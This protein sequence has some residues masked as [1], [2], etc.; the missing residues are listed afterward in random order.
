MLIFGSKQG[1]VA[2]LLLQ[3]GWILSLRS[4]N[5]LSISK[6]DYDLVIIGAGASGLFA[7]G[8]A[9]S[10]GLKTLLLDKA[11]GYVGGDC[12]NS[13]CVPSKAVR[14]VARL[15]HTSRTVSAT[16]R[17]KPDD[18]DG[19]EWVTLAR[20]HATDTVM[21]LRKREDASEIADRDPNL[22]LGFVENCKFLNK[23]ELEIHEWNETSP[24]RIKSKSFLLATG[25]SP[26]VPNHL[27][28][29]A[30]A[31]DVP[32]YTY[33]S[34]LQP[35]GDPR[36]WE[37]LNQTRSTKPNIVLVGGGA[38]ACELGQSL[39][40]LGGKEWNVTIVAPKIM[41]S[42]DV[43]L[44]NAALQILTNDG[45]NVLLG[46]KV[47]NITKSS[48]QTTVLLSD[49]SE[50]PVDA[51]VMCAGRSAGSNLKDLN[52]EAA[53]VSWSSD[54]G[55]LVSESTLQS[56]TEPNIYACGDCASAVTGDNRRAAHGAWTGFHA[57]RN[58]AVP[59][60]L[61]VGSKSTH[62]FVPRVTFT[63]PE[64]A[65]VGLS[66]S[67]CIKKYGKD[68]F[69]NVFVPEEGM[70]RADMER[71][72]RPALGFVELRATKIGGVI[73][74]MTACGP[75]AAELSNEVVVALQNKLSVLD[76]ARS[77]HSYPSHGYLL[78]RIALSMALGSIYGA[79]DILGPL[80]QLMASTGRMMS[81]S[82]RFLTLL[83]PFRRKRLRMRREWEYEGT[84]AG[85]LTKDGAIISFLQMHSNSSKVSQSPPVS[86][87]DESEAASYR[88]WLDRE[89]PR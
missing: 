27:I 80:A 44:Q 24:R 5:G 77:I 18:K 78:H 82:T 87:L 20:K 73:L 54:D 71:L 79:L 40:R 52:L 35:G 33:R 63:D 1:S 13:A 21:E 56:K 43:T 22:K 88:Q 67:E 29:E 59:W 38:T 39:A 49:G 58:M 65:S 85:A 57:A 25:A 37:M 30:G 66:H 11:K 7:S 89:P 60:I 75:A 34:L 3:L 9:T 41:P 68:G 83:S 53:G 32:L 47:T 64:M 48:S 4:C 61:R 6:Y 81:R 36:I 42:E 46:R 28:E 84:N 12:S 17:N 55:V 76:L 72:E 16:L 70:D 23:N 10:L 31:A 19:N 50:L 8:A 86:F 2:S 45:I 15:A 14:S 26:V 74:G 62:S 69:V 51:V